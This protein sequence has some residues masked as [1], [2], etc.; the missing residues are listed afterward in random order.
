MNGITPIAHEVAMKRTWFIAFAAALLV[1]C[2]ANNENQPPTHTSEDMSEPVDASSDVD[3]SSSSDL[4]EAIDMTASPD[5]RVVADMGGLADMDDASAAVASWPLDVAGVHVLEYPFDGLVREVRLSVPEQTLTGVLVLLHGSG[6]TAETFLAKRRALTTLANARGWLVVV[7]LAEAS[8]GK[9]RWNF[10]RSPDSPRDEA[11]I[12]SMLD[13][14]DARGVPG[15]RYL[16]S[17]SNGGRFAHTLLGQYP[18]RFDAGGIVASNLG[19]YDVLGTDEDRLVLGT[20]GPANVW[21]A[22]GSMDPSIPFEGGMTESGTASS[23]REA[24]ERWTSA[25]GCSGEGARRDFA[26]GYELT[27]SDCAEGYEVVQVAYQSNDH[28]WP[29]EGD[30]PELDANAELMRFFLRHP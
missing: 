4:G 28:A 6:Q 14:L 11:F 21:M 16:A 2:S 7:P 9:T 24:I 22:N 27:W 25:S 1:A 17:F 18:N 29:E 3:A 23:V 13:G 30:V 10:D 5:M 20:T 26:G 12:L 15:P 19:T 8:D